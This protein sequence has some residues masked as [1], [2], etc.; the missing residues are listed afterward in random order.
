[1]EIS[2]NNEQGEVEV[3]AGIEALLEMAVARTCALMADLWSKDPKN[4]KER[5]F[6]GVIS[7]ALPV[8]GAGGREDLTGR[9]SG[10]EVSILLVDDEAIRKLNRTY[11][12][13]DAPTDVLSFPMLDPE[14]GIEPGAGEAGF[15]VDPAPDAMLPGPVMLGDIVISMPT[16]AR[17]AQ[18]YGHTLERELGFLTIHGVLHLLG[19]DHEREGDRVRM[20]EME[21]LVLSDLRL[22]R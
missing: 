11:R 1:M 17:Q 13:K 6:A 22:T 8:A 7:G 15:G 4:P 3:S 19:C 21:E 14:Q 12:G 5:F 20:R 10:G 9:D 16:A 18:E 2:I